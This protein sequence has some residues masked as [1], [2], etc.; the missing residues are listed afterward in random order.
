MARLWSNKKLRRYCIIIV[1]A[2]SILVSLVIKNIV[3]GKAFMEGPGPDLA[4]MS[5]MDIQT[6]YKLYDAVGDWDILKENIFIYKYILDEHKQIT[7]ESNDVYPMIRNYKPDTLLAVYEY[8]SGKGLSFKEIKSIME[9]TDI[10]AALE[11]VLVEVEVNKAYNVYLPANKDQI[12][13]WLSQ[14]YSPDDIISADA[15]A[16]GADVLLEDVFKLKTRDNTWKDVGNKL[17]YSLEEPGATT[18]EVRVDNSNAV[19]VITDKDYEG[20]VKQSGNI[21]KASDG[22]LHND[23]KRRNVDV[24]KYL[25]MGFSVKEVNNAVM[26]SAESG[27]A[28]DE[29]LEY[30]GSGQTWENVIAKY[31]KAE[32]GTIK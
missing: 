25:A 24:D 30:K 14:G 8:A 17:G 16:R 22:K 13:E 19:Q 7:N 2:F 10:G 11:T 32:G 31:S 3:S 15:I 27:I 28:I 18:A 4:V 1:L 29:I 26:L 6:V 12:R 21:A 5:G 23:L 20:I 9:Q